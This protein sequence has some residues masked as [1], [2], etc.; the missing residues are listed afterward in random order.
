VAS[1][2]VSGVVLGAS[3]EQTPLAAIATAAALPD[4]APTT[5]AAL[6]PEAAQHAALIA[7]E[8]QRDQAAGRAAHA[9]WL[10]AEEAARLAREEA[11]RVARAEA[12]RVAAEQAA[13]VEQA[14]RQQGAQQAASRSG[15]RG[16][17]AKAIAADLVAARGWSAGQFDCLDSLWTKESGWKVSADN[18]TSSAYG[19]PQALP[20][21]KM[22]SAGGDWRTNP[23]TQIVWGLDYIE[24][25]YGSPCAAWSHS[26]ARNWY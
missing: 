19:I 17:S 23:R 4:A 22:A 24:G 2:G 12:E 11:E 15:G 7:A 1:L 13:V 16:G 5:E 25:R 18:P 21:S 9:N 8:Q 20:G 6:L 3:A 26:K 14:R 10:A